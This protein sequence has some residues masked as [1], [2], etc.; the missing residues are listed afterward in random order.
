MATPT[1]RPPLRAR[2]RRLPLRAQVAA[3]FSGVLVL[4]AVAGAISL[5]Q[6]RAVEQAG[7]QVVTR[8]LRYISHLE[9]A[10]LGAKAAANDERGYLLYGDVQFSVEV[11]ERF[12]KV[13]QELAGARAVATPEQLL[14][15]DDIERQLTAWKAMLTNEFGLFVVD[16]DAA[17]KVAL[18]ESR[19]LRKTYETLFAEELT[20][21]EEKAAASAAAFSRRAVVAQRAMAGG[22]LAAVLI[23]VISGFLL[24]R[25]IRRRLQPL[26]SALDSAAAGDFTSRPADTIKDEIGA[27]A[28]SLSST[29]TAIG[30]TVATLADTAGRLSVSARTLNGISHQM[31]GSMES[32]AEQAAAASAAAHQV[33]D[34]V[35]NAASGAEQL[36]ASI[37]EISGSTSGTAGQTTTA[38]AAVAAAQSTMASLDASSATIND[39]LGVI[40]SV[41]GQTH[42]LALNA[43]IEAARAGDAGKGFAVVAAE[44]KELAQET[45]SA[46]GAVARR[47]D[48]IQADAQEAINAVGRIHTVINAVNEGQV[49]IAS[50]VEE[51]S[52]TTSMIGQAVTEAAHCVDEIANN[53][54]SL[55]A[56]AEQTRSGADRTVSA[57]DEVAE[58]ATELA[59]LAA[60]FRT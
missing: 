24:L 43:T 13:R 51:Q 41:A 8:D 25:S 34:S 20:R 42:L 53:L 39:V 46:T 35:N 47:V 30:R 50:A 5:A 29:L 60:L 2:T 7:R 19:V 4:I 11:D 31:R 36:G 16:K 1:D 23:A 14:R 22:F 44:V 45:E 15:V 49:L 32:A 6:T 12:D 27:M 26:V 33:S 9:S 18:N 10:A 54:T 52:V 59:D 58:M 28:G 37:R 17:R 56:S 21:T 55:A 48:A 57:S 3:G 40:R 38:V